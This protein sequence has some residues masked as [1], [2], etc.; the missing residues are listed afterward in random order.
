MRRGLISAAGIASLLAALVIAPTSS[1]A[2]YDLDTC[3]GRLNYCVEWARRS[4]Q[5]TTQ[6]ELS[7]QECQ[8]TG[9]APE[10]RYLNN[11]YAGPAGR[12]NPYNPYSGTVDRRDSNNPYRDPLERTILH[13]PRQL[14]KR[15]GAMPGLTP[16]ALTGA[17][18]AS[19]Y[20]GHIAPRQNKKAVRVGRTDLVIPLPERIG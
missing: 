4:G 17:G 2:Q 9:V 20:D 19:G 6:C 3:S 14:L 5:P 12:G 15:G 18:S 8:K 11:P 16:G 10:R 1:L 7:Y 13:R